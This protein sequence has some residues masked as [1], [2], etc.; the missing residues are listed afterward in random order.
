MRTRSAPP[1]QTKTETRTHACSSRARSVALG[2]DKRAR[3]GAK[4]V[5]AGCAGPWL[6]QSTSIDFIPSHGVVV[7]AVFLRSFPP[8]CRL[9]E[10][11]C[12][13]VAGGACVEYV[14]LWRRPRRRLVLWTVLLND[15]CSCFTGIT[16]CRVAS[17]DDPPVHCSET[18]Y[19]SVV[20]GNQ[21][22]A[23]VCNGVHWGTV[24][25]DNFGVDDAS[26]LCKQLGR[27]RFGAN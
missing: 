14:G 19:G 17:D 23:F 27:S 1:A 13:C 6:L 24:C 22:R 3:S 16:A 4:A 18:D 5:C 20:L 2:I 25:R 26:V 9:C 15:C 12:G 7:D 11:S 21:E 10:V 8:C